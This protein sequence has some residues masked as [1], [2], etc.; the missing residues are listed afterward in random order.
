M[1]FKVGPFH[2]GFAP[3]S[4]QVTVNTVLY[5]TALYCAGDGQHL[6]PVQRP[7]RGLRGRLCAG[8]GQVLPPRPL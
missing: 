5:C 2:C 7:G 3:G 4:R 8:G 1:S 6:R